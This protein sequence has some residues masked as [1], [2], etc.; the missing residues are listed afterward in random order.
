MADTEDLTF[1]VTDPTGEE[2]EVTLPATLVDAFA[3]AEDTRAQVA[4]DVLQMAFTERAHA[5]VHHG[6]GEVGEDLAAAEERALELFEERFG[7]TYGEATG[8]Q[9]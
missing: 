8:H 1:T 5:L 6:E 3:E 4:G 2:S 9:H 7:M